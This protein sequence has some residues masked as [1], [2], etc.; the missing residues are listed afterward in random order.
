[1]GILS[2]GDL[3]SLGVERDAG[4]LLTFDLPLEGHRVGGAPEG[5]LTVLTGYAP[6]HV[7]AGLAGD[8]AALRDVSHGRCPLL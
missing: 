2:D 5:P 1:M 3:G 4:E 7:V 6:A 8:R